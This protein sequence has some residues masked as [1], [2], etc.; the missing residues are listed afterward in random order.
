[1][2]RPCAC[3]TLTDEVR[4]LVAAHPGAD[5]YDIAEALGLP[6]DLAEELAEKLVARRSLRQG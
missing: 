5:A 2:A 1:M 3:T 6:M 4:A